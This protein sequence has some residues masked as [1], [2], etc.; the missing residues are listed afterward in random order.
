[1]GR[2]RVLCF[3]VCGFSWG[4]GWVLINIRSI[5]KYSLSEATCYLLNFS[6]TMLDSE[7]LD[8]N[9]LNYT[10]Y[11]SDSVFIHVYILKL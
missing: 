1:M 4:S 6:T 3:L 5:T 10:I 11:S 7:D 8:G 9:L 2:V